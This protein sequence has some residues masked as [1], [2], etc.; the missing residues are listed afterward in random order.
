MSWN[1]WS[2]S[3]KRKKNVV[4]ITTRAPESNFSWLKYFVMKDYSDL[5]EVKY[6]PI[7]NNNRLKWEEKVKECCAIILYH[8]RLQG[9]V[10]VAN[11]EGALYDNELRYLNT[12]LGREK[13]VVLLDDMEDISEEARWRIL[14]TQTSLDR[15]SSHL[16]LIPEKEK[17]EAAKIQLI[18][19]YKTLSEGATTSQQKESS[20]V[21]SYIS[22]K[23]FG[24]FAGDTEHSVSKN[25]GKGERAPHT[26]KSI[27]RYTPSTPYQI[28]IFSRSAESNYKWL[29]DSLKED[30]RKKS[31]D[32]KGVWITNDYKTFRSGLQRCRF[33]ILYH[34]KKHG[35]LNITNVM[36]SLYDDELRDMSKDLG[37]ENVIV[38]ADDLKSNETGDKE[39]ILRQQP[40]IR[41]DAEDLFLFTEHEKCTRNLQKIREIIQRRQAKHNGP[42]IEHQAGPSRER[43][44]SNKNPGYSIDGHENRITPDQGPTWDSPPCHLGSFSHQTT[45]QESYNTGPESERPEKLLTREQKHDQPGFSKAGDMENRDIVN[46]GKGQ[47]ARNTTFIN[48]SQSPPPSYQIGIFS[49]SAESNY[50]WLISSLKADGRMRSLDI[51]SVYITND[52]KTFGSGLQ[53]CRFAILYH[54]KKHG[55][56]NITDVTDSLY[57]EELQDMSNLLGRENVIVVADH[58][59]SNETGDKEW[60]LRE[61]PRIRTDAEDLF[62]FTQHEKCRR[63]LETIKDIIQRSVRRSQREESSGGISSI[64]SPGSR[65]SGDSE[66]I[67]TKN[68]NKWERT[69]PPAAGSTSGKP[70]RPSQSPLP[71]YRIGI[72]SRCA[73]SHYTWLLDRLKAPDRRR[74]LDIKVVCITNDYKT[75]SSGLETCQFGILYHTLKHGRLNIT[76]VTNSLY[77]G[78]LRNMSHYLGKENVVVVA[79]DLKSN[80]PEEKEEILENQPSIPTYAKDLFLFTEE[81]KC[82]GRLEAIREIIQRSQAKHNGQDTEHQAAPSRERESPVKTHGYCTEDFENR[83]TSDQVSTENS[84]PS[85]SGSVDGQIT[86]QNSDTAEPQPKRSR[87]LSSERANSMDETCSVAEAPSPDLLS[88]PNKKRN[89]SQQENREPRQV[90]L[91]KE[92]KKIKELENSLRL[93]T[94]EI[95]LAVK[96][97]K[98][99]I[100][101]EE[102]NIDGHGEEIGERENLQ[103][104]RETKG[105]EIGMNVLPQEG[106]EGGHG[107]ET[108]PQG[109]ERFPEKGHHLKD[110]LQITEDLNE[111]LT[112]FQDII[113]EKDQK[114][115]RQSEEI[116]NLIDA[117]ARNSEEYSRCDG[118][119]PSRL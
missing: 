3:S 33:A 69:A 89:D 103:Q 50:A 88:A 38:V 7:T 117:N 101:R 28:G 118:S 4:G 20:G 13:V 6:L 100:Q 63:S 8:T 55:R 19:L 56:L 114:L 24:I 47:F 106:E 99:I 65:S 75:F 64:T 53:T 51:K 71:P 30:D 67:G 34:T 48:P 23:A 41:T 90:A 46:D 11:V 32:I 94:L 96:K 17:S 78:E 52:Y 79:D 31:L 25:N 18:E 95:N 102:G 112:K 87:T 73:E 5:L 119:S 74:S 111:L 36:D 83:I 116:K 62:L 15:L 107:H 108:P 97:M 113:N 45:S 27:F 77:D 66:N 92:E 44:S 39:E 57:D 93:L 76:D 58:L 59:K 80:E 115:Q 98:N 86:S 72:F 14:R 85:C 9:R 105:E 110:H 49:R 2:Q 40:R 54:T 1:P 82:V 70:S 35:R 29:I 26:T 61:Q 60:I 104:W 37:R 16:I 22:S 21:L 81:E 12:I 10:N 109:H 84:S 42:D 43:E 68:N 91:S